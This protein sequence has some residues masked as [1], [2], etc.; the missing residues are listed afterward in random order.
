MDKD[1]IKT[2][3]KCAMFGI[4]WIAITATIAILMMNLT[5][6]NFKDVMF[7]EGIVLV[8]L[9][10]FAS[11]SGNPMGLCIQALGNSNSQYVANA[12]MQITKLDTE[13]A[14]RNAKTTIRMGI[15]TVALIIGGI[16]SMVISFII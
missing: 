14:H 4:I 10:L 9:G 6:Y 8:I 2:L 1:Q 16:L 15:S 12:N 5:R 13:K 3:L 7:I 11:V